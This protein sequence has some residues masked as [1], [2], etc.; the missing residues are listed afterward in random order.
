MMRTRFGLRCASRQGNALANATGRRKRCSSLRYAAPPYF[1]TG[2]WV[3]SFALGRATTPVD[4]H[5]TAAAAAG[6]G[7]A[8]TT[9]KTRQRAEADNKSPRGG[10]DALERV[11]GAER[12][13][14]PAAAAVGAGR[15]EAA[16][17]VGGLSQDVAGTARSASLL[18]RR[19]PPVATAGG[20]RS[21]RVPA[22][23][24]LGDAAALRRSVCAPVRRVGECALLGQAHSPLLQAGVRAL[25]AADRTHV[26]GGLAGVPG[27]DVVAVAVSAAAAV[28]CL[29]LQHPGAAGKYLG[30]ERLQYTTVVAPASLSEFGAGHGGAHLAGRRGVCRFPRRDSLPRAVLVVVADYAGAVPDG[31]PLHA[32]LAGQGRRTGRGQHRLL[33]AAALGHQHVHPAAVHPD[34]ARPAAVDGRAGAAGVPTVPQGVAGALGRGAGVDHFSGQLPDHHTHPAR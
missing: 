15:G 32:A 11:S 9:T 18:R 20:G 4:L 10:A 26:G 29:L 25:Q 30:G 7:D 23:P 27:V 31:A 22:Q 17:T 13:L 1:S 19:P 16:Q 34:R 12:A 33:G 21:G 6:G 2:D 3:S 28:Y 5:H 8:V 24:G 14:L